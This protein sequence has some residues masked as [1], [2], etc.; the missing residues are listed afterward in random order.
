MCFAVKAASAPSLFT[1]TARPEKGS[2]VSCCISG[3]MLV[4]AWASSAVG[5]SS[6]A[7][8]ALVPAPESRSRTKGP[9]EVVCSKRPKLL[10]I[11]AGGI[12]TTTAISEFHKIPEL[13][14]KLAV[15]VVPRPT[16]NLVVD[17]VPVERPE[18]T[19]LHQPTTLT[20]SSEHSGP[21]HGGTNL[22]SSWRHIGAMLG[23]VWDHVWREPCLGSVPL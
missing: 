10:I 6:V 3:T 5:A 9:K 18:I 8:A 19:K 12:G 2:R 14:A 21:Y 23:P 4:A 16:G 17:G 13:E 7:D 22:G 1:P 20:D 15:A 11:S